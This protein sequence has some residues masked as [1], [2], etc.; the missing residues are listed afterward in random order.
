MQPQ[1]ILKENTDFKTEITSQDG[2]T[3]SFFLLYQE[4]KFSMKLT[5]KFNP[6]FWENT[7]SLNVLVSEKKW[8]L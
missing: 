8:F 4:E 3:Y 6:F 2:S 7:F 1:P 5:Q